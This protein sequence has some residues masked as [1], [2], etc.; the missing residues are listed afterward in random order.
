MSK[1]ERLVR[2][3]IAGIV[4]AAVGILAI[5][6]DEMNRAPGH[7]RAPAAAVCATSACADLLQ[8]KKEI[9][10]KAGSESTRDG[11]EK[12]AIEKREARL[13]GTAG[14]VLVD[15]FRDR[16]VT[17]VPKEEIEVV[18]LFLVETFERDGVGIVLDAFELGLGEAK[19][20]A[21]LTAIEAE[22]DSLKSEGVI[23]AL[24]SD[25]T[26]KPTTYTDYKAS[27]S[28]FRSR[29]DADS[30]RRASAK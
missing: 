18:A 21:A 7:S 1:N 2:T 17:N 25:G 3:M 14:R 5:S 6:Y 22:I 4:F 30:D 8:L 23:D 28:L 13:L 20:S 27:L 12:A 10:S 19:S 11:E 24:V 16:D 26:I 15:L 9:L 29:D